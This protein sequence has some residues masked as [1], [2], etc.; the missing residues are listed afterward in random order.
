M[1][2]KEGGREE[3]LEW[4]TLDDEVINDVFE[5]VGAKKGR[6]EEGREEEND[7][8]REEGEE[9]GRDEETETKSEG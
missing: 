3:V 4:G 8:G 5:R 7:G 9:A 1:E 6:K 2:E